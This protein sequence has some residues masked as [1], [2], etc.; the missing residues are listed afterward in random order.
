MVEAPLDKWVLRR[1]TLGLTCRFAPTSDAADSLLNV[2]TLQADGRFA[3][4]QVEGSKEKGEPRRADGSRWGG[5]TRRRGLAARNTMEM[6]A[7]WKSVE[8]VTGFSQAC[9]L[10]R[11][12]GHNP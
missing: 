10:C 1:I 4:A 2:Q 5:V 12:K 7:Y 9:R 3:I 11:L 6:R 8:A